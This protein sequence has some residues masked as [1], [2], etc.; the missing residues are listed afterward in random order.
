MDA[1]SKQQVPVCDSRFCEGLSIGLC[2]ACHPDDKTEVCHDCNFGH[3]EKPI[4]S[5]CAYRTTRLYQAVNDFPAYP[6]SDGYLNLCSGCGCSENVFI[7][8]GMCKDGHKTWAIL[9][10]RCIW[11]QAGKCRYLM[12]TIYS[13]DSEKQNQYILCQNPLIKDKVYFRQQYWQQKSRN[14]SHSVMFTLPFDP[15]HEIEC[16]DEH[17]APF[18]EE[19][20]RESWSDSLIENQCGSKMAL[21]MVLNDVKE[22][23]AKRKAEEQLKRT[24]NR[25]KRRR[26]VNH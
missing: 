23:K 11:N 26:I 18:S 17:P 9:C 16:E 12:E 20:Y 1:T 13:K 10:K 21:N 14:D 3:T 22:E 25:I 19:V 2:V 5:R 4:C 15:N 7:G 8:P 6:D 24:K